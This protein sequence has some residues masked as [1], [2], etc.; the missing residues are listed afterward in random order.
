MVG[1][2]SIQTSNIIWTKQVLYIYI[3]IYKCTYVCVY[4]YVYASVYMCVCIYTHT[5]THTHIY[6][7]THIFAGNERSHEF[8]INQVGEQ[9]KI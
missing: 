5:H 3:H 2:E 4:I 8:E 6:I 7:Y 9:R 1:P